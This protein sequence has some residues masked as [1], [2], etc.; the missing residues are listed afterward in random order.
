[1]T[2]SVKMGKKISG[3]EDKLHALFEDQK[4]KYP[5]YYYYLAYVSSDPSI[6]PSSMNNQ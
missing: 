2:A 6:P 1:M 5:P 4:L 3:C